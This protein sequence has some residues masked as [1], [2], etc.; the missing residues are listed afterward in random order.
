M[1]KLIVDIGNSSAKIAVFKADTCIMNNNYTHSDTQVAFAEYL[2]KIS[3]ENNCPA[4]IMSS[5]RADEDLFNELSDK[6]MKAIY[7]SEK[8]PIPIQNK[9]RSPETLGK[10][11]LAAAVGANA[12]F[13]NQNCLIFD[14]GTAL[15]IDFVN[16]KN[17]YLGGNISPGLEMRFK[18]LNTFTKKL[19]L[20]PASSSVENELGTD[21]ESAIRAGVQSGIL[22]EVESYIHNFKQK[23]PDIQIVFT[24]GD[25]FFFEKNLKINIF[26]QPEIVLTGLNRIIDYNA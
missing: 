8:T 1:N 3:A 5:V 12:L 24:G 2:K 10:D 20:V 25:L 14:A 11:R 6:F 26:A 15:T 13:P 18:A 22:S 21:T 4:F 16:Q 17:E 7:L 9:Y 23:Y 19:P